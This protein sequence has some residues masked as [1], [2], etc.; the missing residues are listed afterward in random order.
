[1]DEIEMMFSFSLPII[2]HFSDGN[3][4]VDAHATMDS[5]TVLTNKNEF[6]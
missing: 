5:F 4:S 2:I 3:S 1:M 6:Q